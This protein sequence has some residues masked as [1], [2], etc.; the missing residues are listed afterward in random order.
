MRK[1]GSQASFINHCSRPNARRKVR[2]SLTATQ[3]VKTT[4][5][6]DGVGW[7]ASQ[8]SAAA[9]RNSQKC[10]VHS[11][12]FAHANAARLHARSALSLSS[13]SNSKLH[14]LHLSKRQAFICNRKLKLFFSCFENTAYC[15][16]NCIEGIRTSSGK[17]N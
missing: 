13:L 16:C 6:H 2:E 4:N 8:P 14:E 15:N 9:C 3:Q 12:S 11:A 7:G 5:Q 17:L 10:A 1:G